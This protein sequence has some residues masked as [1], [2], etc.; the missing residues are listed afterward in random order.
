MIEGLE[1]RVS[2]PEDR[3]YLIE[4][5]NDPKILRWFPMCNYKEVLDASAIWMSYIEKQGVYTATLNGVPVGIANIYVPVYK[6]FAHQCLFAIVVDEK[7]RGKGIGSAFMGEIIKQAKERF[8]IEML[9]LEVYKG[10]PAIRLYERLG[11]KEYGIHKRFFK[12]PWG[13][14]LDKIMMYKFI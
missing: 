9:H 12:E 8:H 2:V 1:F 10:N 11:F 14:Y 7:H 13:E 6:R 4:W 5:L 3:K